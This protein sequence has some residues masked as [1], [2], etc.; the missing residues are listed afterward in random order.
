[1]LPMGPSAQAGAATLKLYCPMCQDIYFPP[2]RRHARLDGVGFGPTFPHLLI[3][4]Y[5]ERLPSWPEFSDWPLYAPRI[6]GF[7]INE[8]SS[9]YP[10]M[11]WLRKMPNGY[12]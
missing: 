1:M 9:M 10:R 2:S 4:Q 5:R 12:R 3:L 6:F 11:K 8:Y 7:R